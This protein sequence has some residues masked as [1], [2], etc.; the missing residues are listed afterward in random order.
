MTGQ[1]LVQKSAGTRSL[2]PT[3]PP[4]QRRCAVRPPESFLHVLWFSTTILPPASM[5]PME[6][7]NK[8]LPPFHGLL[9][10]ESGTEEPSTVQKYTVRQHQL[11]QSHTPMKCGKIQLGF[12]QIGRPQIRTKDSLIITSHFSKTSW[13][14]ATGHNGSPILLCAAG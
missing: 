13:A 12:I 7:L 1:S 2:A 9:R 14:C 8:A 11:A 6:H 3:I 10:E 4:L 5:R